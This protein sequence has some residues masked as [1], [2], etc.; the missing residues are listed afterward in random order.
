MGQGS[1]APAVVNGRGVNRRTKNRHQELKLA[2]GKQHYSPN[3]RYAA[4]MRSRPV[5]S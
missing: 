2:T 5:M 3:R 1:A 4:P